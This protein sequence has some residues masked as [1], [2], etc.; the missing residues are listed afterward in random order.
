[1]H[2]AAAAVSPPFL[3]RPR[4]CDEKAARPTT[5]RLLRPAALLQK[6]T[7]RLLRSHYSRVPARWDGVLFCTEQQGRRG[8]EKE[9]A[10]RTASRRLRSQ[11]HPFEIVAWRRSSRVIC[12]SKMWTT[13][14][15]RCGLIDAA[16]A[17]SMFRALLP[18]RCVSLGAPSVF[19]AFPRRGAV[20]VVILGPSIFRPFFPR[21]GA[22]AVVILGSSIFRPFFPHRGAAA[23]VILGPSIFRPF[24]PHRGA[25][26]V[27]ILGSSIF[28][29]FFPHRGAAAV[30]I[31]GPSIF[32][33]F[34]PRQGAAAVVI[35]GPSIFLLTTLLRRGPRASSFSPPRASPERTPRR[36]APSWARPAAALPW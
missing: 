22:A 25:A 26:A 5:N 11:Q 16:G 30:V 36:G 18:R 15:L 13:P 12:A 31:L 24:F 29:P 8:E 9:E 27:V 14:R 4:R 34:F 2:V 28:R 3:S 1:M 20:V 21:Q 33:L 19:R 23:V 17:P 10:K 32:S 35:L 6:K 7:R